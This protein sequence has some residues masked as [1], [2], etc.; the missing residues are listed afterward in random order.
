MG[1]TDFWSAKEK[2]HKTSIEIDQSMML[3]DVEVDGDA[4]CRLPFFSQGD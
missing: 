3:M 2:G 4:V 1:L